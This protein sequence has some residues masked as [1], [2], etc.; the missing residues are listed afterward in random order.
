MQNNTYIYS[1]ISIAG[2]FILLLLSF[3]LQPKLINIENIDENLINQKVRIR[4]RIIQEKN[5]DNDFSVLTIKDKT[6]SIEVT[7][8]CKNLQGKNAEIIGRI[9]EYGQELQIQ[10]DKIIEITN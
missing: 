6:A 2:I 4:G 7:C 8:N 10:A 3:I 5:Y 9:T 1:A